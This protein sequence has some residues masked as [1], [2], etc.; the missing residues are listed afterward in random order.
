MKYLS[1]KRVS[2]LPVRNPLIILAVS[3]ERHSYM[4]TL[5]R[6]NCSKQWRTAFPEETWNACRPGLVCVVNSDKRFF[7][8]EIKLLVFRNFH[9]LY[10]CIPFLCTANEKQQTQFSL[11]AQML[12]FSEQNIWIVG[13]CWSG[14]CS[15]QTACKASFRSR[16]KLKS[17][18][19]FIAR[20]DDHQW[21]RYVSPSGTHMEES[22]QLGGI[23]KDGA[24]MC[25]EGE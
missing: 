10:R 23:R 18:G 12:Y 24:H 3:C 14:L 21:V 20:L 6:S 22:D 15:R 16:S 4:Y 2:L 11:V 19:Q 13:Q 9:K 1:S 8:D 7:G 25:W 17:T 5:Q